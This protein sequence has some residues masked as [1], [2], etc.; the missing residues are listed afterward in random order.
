VSGEAVVSNTPVPVTIGGRRVGTIEFHES[1][2][3]LGNRGA[4]RTAE[5]FTMIL[6]ARVTL[7]WEPDSHRQ[8]H[9]S[10]LRVHVYY[11]PNS[12]TDLGV[13]FDRSTY[14][15]ADPRGEHD[16]ELEWRGAPDVLARIEK[17]RSGTGPKLR[18][19]CFAE[20]CWVYFQERGG[21]SDMIRGAPDRVYGVSR[22]AYPIEAWVEHMN[23]IGAIGNVLVDM[24]VPANCPPGWNDIFDGLDEARRNLA[25]GGEDGW[26]SCVVAVR[27]AFEKWRALEPESFGIG[28][29]A[30]NQQQRMQWS[31]EERAEAMRYQAYQY[32]HLSA[33][34]HAQRWRRE[35][36]ILAFTT[37]AALLAARHP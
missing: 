18:L 28:W 13:A 22:V 16:L 15:A 7:N 3:A 36:A 29:P 37:L 6:P 19:V 27:L 34:S 20:A 32:A 5:G 24:P 33:H 14:M 2:S 9:L 35:D 26:K 21:T 4:R 11:D 1:S 23:A 12:S 30:A 8:P 25:R 10:A 31:K 17:L